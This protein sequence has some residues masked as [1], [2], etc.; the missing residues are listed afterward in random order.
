MDIDT[1]D[2]EWLAGVVGE[3]TAA[4]WTGEPATSSCRHPSVWAELP[5]GE[6]ADRILT[7]RGE[8]DARGIAVSRNVMAALLAYVAAVERWTDAKGGDEAT[9]AARTRLT[10]AIRRERERVGQRT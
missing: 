5:E 7:E 9:V 2:L 4:P 6:V 1:S 8:A 3:M 10:A